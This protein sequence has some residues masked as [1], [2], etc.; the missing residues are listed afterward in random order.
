MSRR[1]FLWFL[2]CF[3]A[4]ALVFGSG[5]AARA[6][7]NDEEVEALVL[8][9]LEGDY[10]NTQFKDAIE[11]LELAKQACESKKACSPKVRAKVYIAIGTVQAGGFKDTGKAKEAF[12]VALKEDPTASL[13][14]DYIT[15]EVQKAFNDAR[16]VAS[17]STGS[18]E[19]K[20]GQE[21]KP[22]K[23]Y[24]G[25]VKPP[26]GWKSGEAYF[27]YREAQ[28]AERDRDWV[29]CNDYAQAALAAENR[30]EIRM[31]AASCEER[32]GLWIEALA[33]YKI[34]ADT[35]GSAKY[36]LYTTATRARAKDK[37]LREKIPKLVI[38]KPAKVTDLVVK[39]NDTVVPPEKIGGEIWVNP[40][41]RVIQATGKIEGAEVEFEQVINA[42]EGETATIDIQLVPKG[43]KDRKTV[44]C[45]L[46]AKT[47]DEVAKCLGTAS[48]ASDLTKRMSLEVSG[49]HDSDHVDVVTPAILFGIESPT[50]GWGV[51]GS[52][53]VDVVTAASADII[54]TAS[55]RWTEVRY[56]PSIG[57]HK[58]F[59][60]VDVELHG[61]ASIEPDYLA[62]G[63][64][65]TVSVD[66]V[67]KTITPSLGYD[68]GYD[69][70][71][72]SGT[73]FDVFSRDIYRHAISLAT[74]FVLDKATIFT[75]SLSAIFEIGDTAKPYRFI[76]GFDPAI[77]P[78]VPPGLSVEGVA[79][80]RAA[81][82]LLE[83]VPMSRQRWAIAGRV[84]RRFSSSTLRLS[85]RLYI[86]NWGLKAST[87]DAMYLVDVTDTV[88][89]WPHFRFHGQSGVSFWQLAYPVARDQENNTLT[90][91]PNRVG[92]KELGPM[93]A[94]TLGS[95]GR[96]EFGEKKEFA[97]SLT[98]EVV[99]SR[100]LNHLYILQKFGYFG[101]TAFEMEF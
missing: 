55:P 78:L 43:S 79:E 46:E 61:S 76:P 57:G 26:R 75:P 63:G 47:Q 68:F 38:Q 49:Y 15:P 35:A 31:V 95:G 14:G 23:V 10:L 83:Q 96:L 86:D 19:V 59:G 40:G 30:P 100:Y 67:Q 52:F 37:E 16:G 18:I 28:Q 45:V 71:G 74:T 91:P 56:V 73:A 99:Y 9:V 97:L 70:S 66:L 53:L 8:S 50:S 6:A 98:V 32:A 84:A 36:K 29:T 62:T 27:Y 44:R 58:K 17:A 48:G 12:V 60:D 82:R 65:A 92:D 69:I 72:R 1:P 87:T 33:D 7:S 51:N 81:E 34:V 77:V 22:K 11:K 41:Q 89:V 2:A 39:M 4:L 21:R 24:E 93:L 64:G 13:F 101:A 80:A 85:E 20:P 88:R 94:A 5:P 54:S 90:V 25:G 42:A 3:I